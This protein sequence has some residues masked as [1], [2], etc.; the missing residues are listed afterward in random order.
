M[1]IDGQWAQRWKKIGSGK[2]KRKEKKKEKI[3]ERQQEG[4]YI[5]LTFSSVLSVTQ[6]RSPF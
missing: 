4:V 3:R 6:I 2:S 5:F 1:K